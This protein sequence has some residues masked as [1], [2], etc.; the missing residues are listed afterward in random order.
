[1]KIDRKS[2]I[3]FII[4]LVVLNLLF[5]F[6]TDDHERGD[7]SFENHAEAAALIDQHH[8]KRYVHFLSYFGLYPYSRNMGGLVTLSGLS[9]ISGLSI[10]YSI[11]AFSL[12]LGTLSVLG[13]YLMAKEFYPSHLFGFSAAMLFSLSRAILEFSTWTFSYRGPYLILL[14]IFHFLL[15][16]GYVRSVDRRKYLLLS[17]FVFIA[18]LSLHRMTYFLFYYLIVFSIGMMLFI[19][20]K[21]YRYKIQWSEKKTTTAIFS[22][23]ALLVILMFIPIMKYSFY[24][25]GIDLG[26]EVGRQHFFN[27]ESIIGDFIN[28]GIQYAIVFGVLIITVPI[29]FFFI[30]K[31]SMNKFPFFITICTIFSFTPFWADVIYAIAYFQIYLCLLAGLGIYKIVELMRDKK[32]LG[33]SVALAMVVIIMTI[34][35]AV[36]LFVTVTQQDVLY[37]DYPNLTEVRDE[38]YNC[39]IYLKYQN[40]YISFSNTRFINRK[41]SAYAESKEIKVPGQFDINDMDI[42]SFEDLNSGETDYLWTEDTRRYSSIFYSVFSAGDDIYEPSIIA[43]LS[44]NLNGNGPYNVILMDSYHDVAYAKDKDEFIESLYLKGLHDQMYKIYDDG[45][46]LVV[47]LNYQY[48]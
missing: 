30:L 13:I 25:I 12:M 3:Y 41:I 37:E 36:P 18:L 34:A 24:G 9:V 23:T 10:E 22:F 40:K 16:R 20:L 32:Y 38:T 39:A 2:S 15:I 42:V 31:N 19:N 14:P 7:D 6:P 35:E 8:D 21:K 26:T 44:F 33:N 17:S 43:E 29:G 48:S 27:N 28:I 1:M 45:L 46:E 11:L 5:R 4:F 47:F